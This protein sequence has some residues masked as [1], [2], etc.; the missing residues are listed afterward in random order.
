[1]E[2][3][4]NISSRRITSQ[5]SR[6]FD[7]PF[8]AYLPARHMLHCTVPSCLTP[9]P[10]FTIYPD[11]TTPH[12]TTAYH[13]MTHQSRSNQTLPTTRPDRPRTQRQSSQT[14]LHISRSLIYSLSSAPNP[15][16]TTHNKEQQT[17]PVWSRVMH[18]DISSG[19]AE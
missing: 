3:T 5:H 13:N 18:I 2:Q 9:A 10:H 19:T 14:Q 16:H 1:M 12:L 7:H 4:K 6:Q 8:S 15:T 11:H 17:H